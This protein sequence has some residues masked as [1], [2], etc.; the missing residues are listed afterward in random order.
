MRLIINMLSRCVVYGKPMMMLSLFLVLSVSYLP[1]V[2]QTSLISNGKGYSEKRMRELWNER[3]SGKNL[4]AGKLISFYPDPTYHLTAKGNSDNAD[5]TDGYLVKRS[6]QAIWWSPKAVAWGRKY[7]GR[8]KRMIIDLGETKCVD[9]IVWRVVAGSYKRSFDG[10]K[11]VKLYGSVDGKKIHLISERY[12]WSEDNARPNNYRLPNIGKLETGTQVYVY[13]LTIGAENHNMRFVVMEFEQDSDWFCCDELAVIKGS[14]AG[15]DISK[16]DSKT[17][18][19]EDV[20]IKSPEPELPVVRGVIMP[21]WFKQTDFRKNGS[22]LAVKY[23]FQLPKGIKMHIPKAYRY[24]IKG[25]VVEVIN[26]KGGTSDKIGPFF[27]IQTKDLISPVKLKYQAVGVNAKEQPMVSLSLKPEKIPAPFSLK[28]L[29]ISIGWM[30][31]A[32]QS[33]SYW[34]DFVDS[35]KRLGFN[36]IPSFPR[37]W[38]KKVTGADLKE[39][40]SLSDPATATKYGRRLAHLKKLGFKTV[41][42][43]SPLHWVCRKYSKE[44]SEFRCGNEPSSKDAFCPTYRGKYYIDEMKRIRKNFLL[45]GGA[46]YIIWD[47]ELLG[48]AKWNGKGCSRCQQFFKA[49][50]VSWE[51]FLRTKTIE[52]LQDMKRQVADAAKMH[53]WA[54]PEVGMYG[55]DSTHD[56]AGLVEF[57]KSLFDFQN[58]SLYVGNNSLEIHSK[59]RKCRE[60]NKSNI[61]PWLTTQTAGKVSPKNARIMLWEALMNGA[62][63]ATYYSLTDLNPAQL[64]EICRALAAVAP[65]EDIIVKGDLAYD[66][67]KVIKGIGRISAIR[68]GNKMALLVVN[69]TKQKQEIEWFHNSGKKGKV[70]IDA[71]DGKLLAISIEK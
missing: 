31:D 60:L 15:K 54:Q 18:Q 32:Q 67:F 27:F 39:I 57:R 24:K 2:G 46:D 9:K 63:G 62:Q 42:M 64:Y 34:P 48:S 53:G 30:I 47:C 10:P 19:I 56:Y 38:S 37:S 52:I 68:Y 8:Y 69:P 70:I 23:R 51:K 22:K 66:E 65:I 49:S 25:N 11:W 13:P 58:P 17:I 43:E 33:D 4:A 44:S 29:T 55:V 1:V 28:N 61:I 50:G 45:M 40:E 41:Y 7:T 3:I 59:I 71:M 16:L 35:Y 20:W 36:T 12:R 26:P 21:V 6:G 5:L 14:G